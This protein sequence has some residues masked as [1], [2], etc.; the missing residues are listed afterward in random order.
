MNRER[1][2]D[3]ASRLDSVPPE[4]FDYNH[5]V[6]AGNRGVNRQK[7]SVS[8]H[9]ADHSCGTKGCAL[10][11]CAVWYPEYWVLDFQ[12]DPVLRET[13]AIEELATGAPYFAASEFFGINYESAE[14]LFCPNDDEID[15]TPHQVAEKIR[16]FVKSIS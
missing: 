6:V 7:R 4:K 12:S 8:Q 1:L 9:L 13:A 15:F 16:A 10:G 2:L 11:W 3:L 5:F 14:E